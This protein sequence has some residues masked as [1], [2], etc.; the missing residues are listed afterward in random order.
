MGD[1]SDIPFTIGLFQ[2]FNALKY[3]MIYPGPIIGVANNY[4]NSKYYT[5]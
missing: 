2:E 5:V 3:V 1:V 4:L